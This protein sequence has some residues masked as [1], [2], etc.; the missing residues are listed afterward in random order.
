VAA[1]V[2]HLTRSTG[3]TILLTEATRCL[4]EGDVEL[5]PR[6]EIPLKGKTDP[7]PVYAP[8]LARQPEA[9]TQEVVGR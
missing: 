6:G 8:V 9:A 7:V 1:R 3:D 4:L 5:E 2:E